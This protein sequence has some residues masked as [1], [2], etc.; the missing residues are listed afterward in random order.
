[1]RRKEK[2]ERETRESTKA[3]EGKK[4]L[5]RGHGET[6][7]TEKGRAQAESL[8]YQSVL[9]FGIPLV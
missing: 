4:E 5:H 8:C 1:M 2:E 3:L 6:E 7:D 9:Q